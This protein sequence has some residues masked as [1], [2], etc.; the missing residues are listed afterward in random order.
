MDCGAP[1]YTSIYVVDSYNATQKNDSVINVKVKFS[2]AKGRVP[3]DNITKRAK[4]YKSKD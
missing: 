4:A 3:L 1:V 2:K